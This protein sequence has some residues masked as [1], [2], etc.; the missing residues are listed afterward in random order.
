[1]T[2]NIYKESKF[3]GVLEKLARIKIFT[4]NDLIKTPRERVRRFTVNVLLSCRNGFRYQMR[5]YEV[6]VVEAVQC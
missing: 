2:V 4:Q 5:L 6:N 1:M 3:R